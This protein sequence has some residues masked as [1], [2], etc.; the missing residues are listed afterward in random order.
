[1]YLPGMTQAEK[2]L[3]R[4]IPMGH[5]SFSHQFQCVGGFFPFHHTILRYQWDVLQFNSVLTLP[6]DRIRSQRLRAQSHKTAPHFRRQAQV[7]VVTCASDQQAI[8]RRFPSPPPTLPPPRNSI[9]LLKQLRELWKAVYSLDYPFIT[10]DI[11]GYKSTR[12]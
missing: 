11:N 1:M 9:N 3:R 12:A 7:Q 4:V 10:R 5:Y 8:N 6:R 2:Y